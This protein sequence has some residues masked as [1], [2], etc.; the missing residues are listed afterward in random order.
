MP[1]RTTPTP[2]PLLRQVL[3]WAALSFLMAGAAGAVGFLVAGPAESASADAPVPRLLQ[4]DDIYSAGVA[5]GRRAVSRAR[6][7]GRRAGY[8]EGLARGRRVA[9]EALLRRFRPGGPDHRRIFTEGQRAGERR[10]LERFGFEADGFY[11]VG[12]GEGGRRVDARHGPLPP[13]KAYVICRA[14]RAVCVS[15]DDS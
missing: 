10:A 6:A 14:G 5:Q 13:D 2:K 9:R 3:V 8:R 15:D 12:I 1:R 11:V 7:Q 4:V